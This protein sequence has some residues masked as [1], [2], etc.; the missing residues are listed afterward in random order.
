MKPC[1]SD[2]CPNAAGPSGRCD[3]CT[4]ERRGGTLR[5][6]VTKVKNETGRREYVLTSDEWDGLRQ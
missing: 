2:Y 6:G 4:A 3:E 5:S 1:Q